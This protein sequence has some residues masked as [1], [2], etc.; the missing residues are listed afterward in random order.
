[1]NQGNTSLESL[2]TE[3]KLQIVRHLLFDDDTVR[4]GP[5]P[6]N[7]PGEPGR[8]LDILRVSKNLSSLASSVLYGGIH[9][10][11]F[12]QTRAV[13]L[14]GSAR[15]DHVQMMDMFSIRV[16]AQ[17]LLKRLS[18]DA[19]YKMMRSIYDYAFLV[20]LIRL[21]GLQF[22]RFYFDR[23]SHGNGLRYLDDKG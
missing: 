6:E 9:F 3:I 2:P 11:V 15:Q 20:Q 5:L 12:Q 8:S 10:D 22:L 13:R 7:E 4:F 18:V 21:R 23:D 1:M 19:D 17:T 14:N 16:P